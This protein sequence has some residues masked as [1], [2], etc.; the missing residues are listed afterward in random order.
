MMFANLFAPLAMKVAGGIILALLVLLAFSVWRADTL[1][2][3]RDSAVEARITAEARHAVT[4]ASLD[5]LEGEL[6][7]MVEDSQLR[8][9]RRDDALS[10][11]EEDTR[12]LRDQAEALERGEIDV[13]EVEGL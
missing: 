10:Q 8:A 7:K 1:S 4:R 3:Q 12:P 2:T 6:A 13:T 11:V 9:A 5:A